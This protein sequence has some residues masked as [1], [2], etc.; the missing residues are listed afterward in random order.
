M[1]S[2]YENL[3]I[4]YYLRIFLVCF[5]AFSFTQPTY[6]PLIS[7]TCHLLLP[8]A[9]EP[10]S[11]SAP[12][13]ATCHLSLSPTAEPCQRPPATATVTTTCHRHLLLSPA[14]CN[15]Q[16]ATCHC[17]LILSPVH[18]CTCRT[19]PPLVYRF[20]GNKIQ[21]S[22]VHFGKD[23]PHCLQSFV[24]FFVC[25]VLLPLMI[26]SLV[27]RSGNGKRLCRGQGKGKLCRN[28]C[29]IIGSCRV[30]TFINV[31]TC[32]KTRLVCEQVA[33]GEWGL[34]YKQPCFCYH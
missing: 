24:N 3:Y 18:P 23:A 15:F 8:P 4:Y 1:H 6:L 16:P 7:A 17:H 22:A 9:T 27:T 34:S 10:S 14:N 12:A 2:H 5:H 29:L 25:S 21:S 32:R 33:A 30:W 31:Q 11:I 13:T 19:S 20:S 26:Y 28:F